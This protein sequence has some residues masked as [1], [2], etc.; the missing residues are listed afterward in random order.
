MGKVS[1]VLSGLS[2]GLE[3]FNSKDRDQLIFKLATHTGW[4]PSEIEALDIERFL[5]F[6]EQMPKKTNR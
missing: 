2:E 4:Q 5:F 6:V 3:R 1:Q